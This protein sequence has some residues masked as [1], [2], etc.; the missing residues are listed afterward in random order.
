MHEMQG[1]Q[2]VKCNNYREEAKL[3]IDGESAA[4][5]NFI[6]ISPPLNL[7]PLLFKPT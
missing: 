3:R 5:E 2:L 6:F 4:S 7:K 1:Y